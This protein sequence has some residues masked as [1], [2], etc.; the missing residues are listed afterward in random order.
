[1]R[2]QIH[3]RDVALALERPRALSI[4]NVLEGRVAE[5]DETHG[6]YAEVRCS[7]GASALLA[8]ITR[9]S[10]QRL[11]LVPGSTVFVLVKSVALDAG[12]GPAAPDR[13]EM[14]A[15]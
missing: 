5:I 15:T 12:P 13:E 9:E 7:V 6:P 8:R 2:V 1:M 11:G 14:R 10:V 3:A 4:Q